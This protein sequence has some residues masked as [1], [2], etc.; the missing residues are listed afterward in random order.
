MA[1]NFFT[2]QKFQSLTALT[3]GEYENCTFID[4]QLPGADLSGFVLDH[5]QWIY[6]DLSMAIIK[7]T[8][9]R[10]N[11]FDGCKLL[12]IHF[13]DA[14]PFSISFHFKVCI[15]NYASFFQ[16]KIPGTKFEGC[17]MAEVN[18]EEADLRRSGFRECHLLN[19]SFDYARL[20]E[21]D[22]RTAYDFRINPVR[23]KLQGALFSRNNLEGLLNQFGIRME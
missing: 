21:A 18:L 10:E 19:A 5:C 3:P 23:C 9:I 15:L 8:S 22:F 2:N 1:Y 20:E 14:N 12:G 11:F 16:M 6:C 4:C 13:E 7:G 17:Q